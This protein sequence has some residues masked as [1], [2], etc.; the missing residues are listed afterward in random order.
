[1]RNS[2]K[3]SKLDLNVRLVGVLMVDFDG[4]ETVALTR[5][6]LCL[7]SDGASGI[8]ELK[9]YESTV[10]DSLHFGH[11]ASLPIY[12]SGMLSCVAQ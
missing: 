7:V 3:S 9:P 2:I 1:M 11:L 6:V 5:S 8:V 10:N 4:S 12:E